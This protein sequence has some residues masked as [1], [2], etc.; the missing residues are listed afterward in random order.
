MRA[1]IKTRI[2]DLA[3][4]GRLSTEQR[5]E[6]QG[7][8]GY[9]RGGL[10]QGDGGLRLR[11]LHGEAV[12]RQAESFGA[13]LRAM[14]IHARGDVCRSRL[15]SEVLSI[16]TVRVSGDQPSLIIPPWHP[17]RMKA[18]AVKTRRV[19]GLVTHF[20]HS[21]N[22]LF[23]DREIFFREFSDELAHPFYPEIAVAQRAGTPMLVS[24]SST[25]NGYSLLERPVRGDEDAMTDVDPTAAAKQAR[26]LL[27]RYVGVAAPR[28]DQSER[29]ALQRRRGRAAVGDGA[30]ALRHADGERFPMQR[31]GPPSRSGE[32]AP[33]LRRAGQQ[34]WR[35]SR[36]AGGQRDLGKLHFEAAYLGDAS[37]G[38]ASSG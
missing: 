27:E 20:S 5:D 28:G 21:D 36:P 30:R 3:A 10:H 14:A 15:V 8:V 26:E 34:G 6:L 1:E 33:R 25:V 11:G 29:R 19:A 35:R 17:E 23:G 13:L 18:L 37:F 22:V 24:E 38:Y 2:K 12:M 7:L 9:L 32:A 4:E 31:V 16:G